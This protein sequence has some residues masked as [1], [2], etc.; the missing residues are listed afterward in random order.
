[1]GKPRRIRYPV[2]I[3]HDRENARIA[4][5]S[6]FTQNFERPK[7]AGSNRIAR[8]AIAFHSDP[9]LILDNRFSLEYIVAKIFSPAATDH[10]VRVSMTADFMSGT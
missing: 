6:G 1:M 8:R 7:G 4:I 5:K 10:L 3:V 2:L 9:E